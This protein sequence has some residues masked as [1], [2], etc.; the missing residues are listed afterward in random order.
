MKTIE[1]TLIGKFVYLGGILYEI[2]SGNIGV[3]TISLKNVMTGNYARHRN[4]DIE[5]HCLSNDEIFLFDSSF[6]VEDSN[7]FV[8]LYCSNVGLESH[9]IA[10]LDGRLSIIDKC[11][12]LEQ[13]LSHSFR[14][15]DSDSIPV[16][17]HAFP[18][19]E[20]PKVVVF[21][22]SS[23]E[24]FDYIFGDNPDY[25]PFWAS[26]WSTRGLKNTEKHI[27]PYRVYLE[28]ISSDSIIL[29][30][31]GS[32]DIDFNLAFKAETSGFYH[33]DL[34]IKEMVDGILKFRKYLYDEFGISNIYAV[35]SAPT[36]ELTPEYYKEY[37]RFDQLPVKMRSKMLW[38]FAITLASQMPV[39]NCLPDLVKS[40][41]DPV[42]DN[43]YVRER[44]DHHIDFV[45]IQDVVY[46]KIKKVPNML[47]RRYSK[48]IKLYE[49][50]IYDV[51]DAVHL[52]KPRPRTCR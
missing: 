20:K 8:I 11:I 31:F 19:D 4:G 29:L 23:S 24:V 3:D 42:C 33:T 50:L 6:Y 12:C 44:P 32:V 1:S 9:C 15:L 16:K 17:Q 48:H 52:N 40:I 14:V 27:K 13:S 18:Q 46:N 2:T 49:H 47:P 30:H 39:V 51:Y 26:G 43:K 38:D 22:S 36:I 25:F 10:D 5:N 34:F 35:F 41:D 7:D 28:N 21:G 45:K 37:F